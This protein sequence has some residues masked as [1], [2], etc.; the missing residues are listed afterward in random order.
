M[1]G[2][3][4]QPPLKPAPK[5][6][7]LRHHRK[8]EHAYMLLFVAWLPLLMAVPL[9]LHMY[10]G[11]MIGQE[12]FLALLAPRVVLGM[13]CSLLALYFRKS[14]TVILVAIWTTEIS[15]FLVEAFASQS[16]LSVW[17]IGAWTLI[18][19]ILIITGGILVVEKVRK[20]GVLSEPGQLEDI[21]D[22]KNDNS[23]SGLDAVVLNHRVDQN[24]PKRVQRDK[25]R[26][27][28]V[29][30]E[31]PPYQPDYSLTFDGKN[32]RTKR[33]PVG[34]LEMQRDVSAHQ[35]ERLN[36]YRLDFMASGYYDNQ[37]AGAAG[38]V[39]NQEPGPSKPQKLK[40]EPNP[41]PLEA[42]MAPA[43]SAER[44]P[45]QRS[46]RSLSGLGVGIKNTKVSTNLQTPSVDYPMP[47]VSVGQFG[48]LQEDNR[49]PSF[50]DSNHDSLT[51][52]DAKV[53]PEPFRDI[54]FEDFEANYRAD[55]HLN[56][57]EIQKATK[58]MTDSNYASGKG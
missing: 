11:D 38:M 54:R 51:S 2:S 35:P 37:E 30:E 48:G 17:I 29:A 55:P 23:V 43:N 24:P 56:R 1:Q 47:L 40:L 39:Q 41:S 33:P 26:V 5:G 12:T 57:F 31:A 53:S 18:Q 50:M 6:A 15:M 21:T 9:L 27:M 28:D 45:S 25:R 16:V 20:A 36:N 10:M 7:R 19:K 49:S 13:L 8:S 14:G 46:D 3:S 22:N 44:T 42:I 58:F 34:M 4:K 32:E 52:G